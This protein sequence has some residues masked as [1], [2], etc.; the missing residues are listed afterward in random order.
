MR[1]ANSARRPPT[2]HRP[3][4]LFDNAIPM[5]VITG[6]PLPLSGKRALQESACTGINTL[7]IP[8]LHPP[9]LPVPP[10]PGRDQAHDPRSSG[11]PRAPRTGAPELSLDIMKSPSPVQP[12][13]HLDS[14]IHTSSMFDVDATDQ[15]HELLQRA[16]KPRLVIGGW[17]GE[18]VAPSSSSP[19]FSTS[20]SSRPRWQRPGQPAAPA[21]PGR[22]RL[23][24][25]YGGA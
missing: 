23:C 1:C 13:H 6:Q 9:R 15:L 5:L 17:C 19:S 14:I 2:H 10:R 18:A 3:P 20:P 25:A 12:S 7:G 8:P 21:Q 4:V 16:R 22:L 24:R 11:R